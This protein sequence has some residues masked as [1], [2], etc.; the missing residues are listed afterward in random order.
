[1]D[2]FHQQYYF[3]YEKLR[4]VQKELMSKVDKVISK[5]GRLIVHAPTGLGKT[6]ATLCPALKHAIEND[7]T[8]FFLTSRHTQHLIAIETLKEMKEK[9]GLNIVTTD[10]IG[11]KWMCPVPGT[12]RL[13]SRDFSEYC[14]SVR[15]SNS[16]KFILNTKK[17]KKLTPKAHAIIEKIGDLSPCDSER[18]IELCTDDMLCPYE[19]TT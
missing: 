1:M 14:R 2:D 13:Y 4:D 9:F 3:P 10:I 8:V 19:I 11:K 18:L 7:L 17:G 5:R 12:D 15:E 16:C 6:V